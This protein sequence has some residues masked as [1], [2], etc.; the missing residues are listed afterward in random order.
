[1]AEVLRRIQWDNNL[2][3]ADFSFLH[4]DRVDDTVVESP[5][6]VP[7]DSVSGK[8]SLLVDA[9]PEHRIV[10]VK[11]KDR[12]VWDRQAKLDRVFA[13]EGI[14]RVIQGYD[15]WKRRE[16]ESAEKSRQRQS[17]VSQRIRFTLGLS[18]FELLKQ[19]S[20]DMLSR[21]REDRTIS[22]KQ[23]AEKYVQSALD[24]FRQ[25]RNDPSDSLQPS[26]IP[27]S[28]YEALENL[29]ELVALLPDSSASTRQVI[30]EE[31]ALRM[32]QGEGRKVS[33]AAEYFASQNRQLPEL[34]E[35]ELTETFTR[36][37]GPG[38][39]KINKTSSRVVLIHE[40][41]QL[42]V[43]CQDTRSLQQNRKIARK[44]LRQKLDEHLYGS[45]SKA[46]HKAAKASKK[47]ARAKARNR[48]RLRQKQQ[49]KLAEKS[50][51]SEDYDY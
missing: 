2:Q 21:T 31:V 23:E 15:E 16:D 51:T 1:V 43:E 44:R 35:E 19:M 40:P 50:D 17:E 42:R 6:D 47:K 3:P 24:L 18:R 36:G 38:G 26:L 10:A 32:L 41:T 33:S 29:S 20:N 46:A 30:L 49:K 39:Q 45:Q 27:L 25:I 5:L 48:A 11:F 9:L 14:E 34:L 22:V 4:Y 13:N 7:N 8:K 28:D 37:S 12:V